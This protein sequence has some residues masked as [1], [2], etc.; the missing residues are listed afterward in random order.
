[1]LLFLLATV[2]IGFL[3]TDHASARTVSLA[4]EK[5]FDSLSS[6]FIVTACDSYT[7]SEGCKKEKHCA[8]AGHLAEYA[9]WLVVKGKSYDT[10]MKEIANRYEFL[11]SNKKNNVDLKNMPSIGNLNA[12]VTVVVYVLDM[13]PQCEY[14]FTAMYRE[15]TIGDL[16][17]KVRIY[18]KPFAE[19]VDSMETVRFRAFWKYIATIIDENTVVEKPQKI[20]I[21]GPPDN[22]P[23]KMMARKTP[24]PFR[25]SGSDEVSPLPPVFINGKV[26][27]SEKDTRWIVDAILY[28]YEKQKQKVPVRR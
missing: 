14:F 6:A 18:A 27:S 7:I 21:A 20:K 25:S 17:G 16:R 3:S 9:R 11:T 22:L 12:P 23:Y 26:Y 19:R 13:C 1:M 15:A 28:E 4:K 5:L 10:C 24:V 2:G 8:V